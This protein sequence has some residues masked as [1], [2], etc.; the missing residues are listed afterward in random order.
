MEGYAQAAA[1]LAM[2][3]FRQKLDFSPES[4]DALDEILVQL[5]E[6]PDAD[7]E[8]DVRLW[9]SY[10]GEVLAPVRRILGDDGLPRRYA[11][12]IAQDHRAGSG[13]HG[14]GAGVAALSAGQGLPPTDSWR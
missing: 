3:E 7:L 4:A 12:R 14:R 8:F 6:T 2:A 11:G 13:P 1:D 10:L 5:G 9:G